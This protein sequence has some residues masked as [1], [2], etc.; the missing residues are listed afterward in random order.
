MTDHG[1]AS[2]LSTNGALLDPTTATALLDAGLG[3]VDEARALLDA[4]GLQP[5]CGAPFVHMFVGFDGR[6]Y[7]C[8]SD[9]KKEVPLGT[10]FDTS[11]A[12][13]TLERLERVR[14]RL[15]ICK[16]CSLDPV[17]RLAAKLRA[18]GGGRAE[19]TDVETLVADVVTMDYYAHRIVRDLVTGD[20]PRR[21]ELAQTAS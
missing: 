11:F 7:L 6:Y 9:W 15:P 14:P 16:R 19:P 4:R 10:V 1:F 13:A 12:A 5:V 2:T 17:N 18:I 21:F 8:S 3:T 20:T